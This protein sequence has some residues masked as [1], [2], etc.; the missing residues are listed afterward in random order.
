MQCA[1]PCSAAAVESTVLMMNATLK[2][3]GMHVAMHERPAPADQHRARRAY[4]AALTWAFTL[5]NSVRMLSYLPT[6][7]AIYGS[8]DSS[9]FVVDLVDLA[10]RQRDDGGLAVRAERPARGAGGDRQ[11]RQRH[12]V[13]RY[14]DAD[15]RAP[16]FVGLSVHSQ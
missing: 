14:G 1:W 12:D 13:R 7:W 10:G 8:G 2:S 5:F 15:R 11:P 9:Q 6:M 3:L 16:R 4:L